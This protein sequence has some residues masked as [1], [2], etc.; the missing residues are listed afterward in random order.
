VTWARG[1][2]DREGGGDTLALSSCV[3]CGALG[4]RRRVEAAVDG[5][6]VVGGTYYHL[7]IDCVGRRAQRSGTS[8]WKVPLGTAVSEPRLVGG[9]TPLVRGH[10][11]SLFG[12]NARAAVA[13]AVL[14][15]GAYRKQRVCHTLPE[16]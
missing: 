6:V 4:V 3:R 14:P 13:R 12:E 9:K 8:L 16:Q 15:A 1:G 7:R 10:D 5:D 11:R 2:G